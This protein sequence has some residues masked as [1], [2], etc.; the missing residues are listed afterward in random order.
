MDTNQGNRVGRLLIRVMERQDIEFARKL[1]NDDSTLLRLSDIEHISE[2]QQEAWFQ[3]ISTSKK[4]KRYTI[5]DADSLKWIGIFRVDMIDLVNR[6]VCVGLDIAVEMRGKGYAK[7]IYRYFLDYYFLH[8]GMHRLY[9]AVLETNAIARNLYGELGFEEE[10][11]HREAIYRDGKYVDLI[12][13]SMLRE[14][15]D[16]LVKKD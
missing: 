11:R 3:S 14:K 15:F 2:V 13:M 1:H 12:W 6:S 4:S 8:A 9:L 16:A 5:L 10:G 7:E